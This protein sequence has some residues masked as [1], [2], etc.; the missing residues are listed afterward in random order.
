MHGSENISAD[1]LEAPLWLLNHDCLP[2]KSQ[3]RKDWEFKV[4][5][6]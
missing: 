3:E 4:P 6:F 5:S 1:A 2:K